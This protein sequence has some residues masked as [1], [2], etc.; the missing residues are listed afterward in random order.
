MRFVHVFCALSALTLMP[1]SNAQQSNP[2]VELMQKASAH[3]KAHGAKTP[4]LSPLDKTILSGAIPVA[5]VQAMGVRII[6]WTT[7][8]LDE[9]H[10]VIRTGVDGL[11][12]D[13]PDLLQQ[14]V[15]AERTSG[16]KLVGF[17]VEG[18]RGGR[19]LR[20]ENTLPAF[21]SGLDNLIDT[22]ETDT[23]VSTDGVSL[24]WHDQFYNPQSCRRQDGAPYTMENRVYLKDISSTDAQK[25]FICDKLHFGDAQKNDAELS[26]VT[27]AFAKQEG[28][29]NIYV[30][31]YVEQLFK[32]VRFY[33]A[34]YRSGAGKSSPHAADRAAAGAKVH[35]NIETKVLPTVFGPINGKKIA[36]NHTVEP[37]R[38]VD[39]LCGVIARTHMEARSDVQSFD[40][41]TLL[42]V[43]E[44]FPKI[45]TVYLTEEPAI[46]S[47]EFLPAALR[48]TK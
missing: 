26:P 42:L 1:I 7:D 37:Q 40:F 33:E 34:Y 3:A 5:Q 28:L 35:F 38:F 15:A 6:P 22:I 21:E 31:T 8:T 18:H 29:A 24:I 12:S 48:V 10:A 2:F 41:R 11:I 19:G 32:F 23:G 20:P 27:V 36:T 13:R 39:V 46:L 4:I 9:M 30:P 43:E 14:A 47:T 17:D 45:Q 25:T 16:R 44:Q